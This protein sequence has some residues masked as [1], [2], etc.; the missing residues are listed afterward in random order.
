VS[1]TAVVVLPSP[2]F[3]GVIAV[4]QTSLASVRVASRSSTESET[5][6]L[7]VP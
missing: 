7:Y 6:A 1:E 4:T 3:V 2:N 5:L